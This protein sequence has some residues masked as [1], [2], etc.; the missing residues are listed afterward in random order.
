[1]VRTAA[2]RDDWRRVGGSGDARGRF[3][4][5]FCVRI[6]RWIWRLSWSRYWIWLRIGDTSG[7]QVVSC[8]QEGLIAGLVVSGFGLA[9]VYIAPLATYLIGAYGINMTVIGLGIGF[10]VVVCGLAQ[11]L[12]APPQGYI[13]EGTAKPVAGQS[14]LTRT[15][16]QVKC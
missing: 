13:P 8:G 10:L 11:L 9:S 3:N 15:S 2:C 12:V 7:S 1:M 6:R 5:K 4:G 16:V 14:Q